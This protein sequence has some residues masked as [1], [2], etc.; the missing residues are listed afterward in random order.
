MIKEI[1]NCYKKNM[2]LK[3]LANSDVD[4]E[5]FCESQELDYFVSGS[6]RSIKID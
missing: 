2:L 5:N 4:I 3:S 6:I 1:S